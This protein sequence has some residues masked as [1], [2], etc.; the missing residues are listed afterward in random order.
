MFLLLFPQIGGHSA[1]IETK[2]GTVR[3]PD[4]PDFLD[5]GI[6]SHIRY[7]I[8]SSGVQITGHSYSAS[9]TRTSS[10]CRNAALARCLQFQVNR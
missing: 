8:S 10:L 1:Q 9:A 6:V 3:P 2:A 5:Y 7:S 4:L